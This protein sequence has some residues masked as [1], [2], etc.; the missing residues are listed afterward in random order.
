MNF[1]VNL[2][3]QKRIFVTK[4]EKRKKIEKRKRRKTQ[5]KNADYEQKERVIQHDTYAVWP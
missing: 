1:Q 2:I 4:M 5:A 3:M